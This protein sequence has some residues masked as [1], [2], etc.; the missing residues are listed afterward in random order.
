MVLHYCKTLASSPCSPFLH[1]F[2][3][4]TSSSLLSTGQSACGIG[5][6]LPS[7]ERPA[8]A[9]HEPSTSPAL[10]PAI[11]APSHLVRQPRVPQ[12]LLHMPVCRGRANRHRLQ[13]HHHDRHYHF[14]HGPSRVADLS[15]ISI[16]RRALRP[17]S[18]ANTSSTTVSPSRPHSL[19]TSS[20]PPGTPKMRSTLHCSTYLT[21]SACSDQGTRAATHSGWLLF[22]DEHAGARIGAREALREARRA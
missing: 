9:K 11:V 7:A 20:T 21:S 5:T 12:P 3:L 15:L 16:M 8:L 2:S 18:R 17:L 13:H 10:W 1:F 14:H 19:T 4:T 6:C 22:Q